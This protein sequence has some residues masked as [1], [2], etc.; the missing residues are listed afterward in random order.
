MVCKLS[1]AVI[2]YHAWNDCAEVAISLILLSFGRGKKKK[3]SLN[4]PF[5]PPCPNPLLLE[6]DGRGNTRMFLINRPRWR[7]KQAPE[8]HPCLLKTMETWPDAACSIFIQLDKEGRAANETKPQIRSEPRCC[9]SSIYSSDSS[10]NFD[11][12]A[13][14]HSMS[15]TFFFFF[16]VWRCDSNAVWDPRPS[17]QT[18]WNRRR[19]LNWNET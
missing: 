2:V 17:F 5:S 4:T 13:Y 10:I 16:N 1:R 3:D 18:F 19:A 8:R 12:T 15:T 11:V 14:Q 7:V 6:A 9:L